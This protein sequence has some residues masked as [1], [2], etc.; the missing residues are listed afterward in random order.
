MDEMN[1][2]KEWT[3]SVAT[4]RGALSLTPGLCLRPDVNR[5][6]SRYYF[7]KV[8]AAAIFEYCEVPAEL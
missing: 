5:S 2:S 7:L 4:I 8:F 6:A 1:E 3:F